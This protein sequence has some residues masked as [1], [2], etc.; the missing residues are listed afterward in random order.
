MT[1]KLNTEEGP[2]TQ[3][4]RASFCPCDYKDFLAIPLNAPYATV[5]TD[6]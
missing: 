3:A 1:V 4:A 5:H 6:T 2:Q